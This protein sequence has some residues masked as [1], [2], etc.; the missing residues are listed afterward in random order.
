MTQ[1]LETRDPAAL[2]SSQRVSELIGVAPV[3]LSRWRSL[4]KGPTYVRLGP[5]RV[6]YPIGALQAWLAS[7]TVE[8]G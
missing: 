5:S 2:L 4:G 7:L 6:G 1:A 8:L 3:T